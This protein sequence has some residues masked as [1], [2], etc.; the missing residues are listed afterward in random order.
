LF[1]DFD[2]L[3]LL[4]TLIG[5]ISQVGSQRPS[6]AILLHEYFAIFVGMAFDE[7]CYKFAVAFFEILLLGL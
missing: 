3:S 7:L 6:T 5:L 2:G 4:D 1:E